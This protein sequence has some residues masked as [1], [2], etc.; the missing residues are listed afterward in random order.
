M[1]H[2]PI[3]SAP[4]IPHDTLHELENGVVP[5]QMYSGHPTSA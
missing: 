3:S 5:A 1:S 4:A 2:I